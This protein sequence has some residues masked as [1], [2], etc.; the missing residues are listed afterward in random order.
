MSDHLSPE[1]RSWNMS[2]IRNRDTKPEIMVRSI[3]HGLA[4]RFTVNGPKNKKLPGKPDIVLP[5]YRTVVFVHGCYWHRHQG[6][7]ET[8]T[9]KTRTEWWQAKFDGNVERD[10]RNQK[11]LRKLGWKVI[12]VWE[13]ETKTAGGIEKTGRR[14]LRLLERQSLPP[15][16]K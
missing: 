6:C 4:F 5:R 8:T 14:L 3:L 7:K 16:D 1:R 10:R 12:V 11:E 9:P 2:R 15:A 13:C